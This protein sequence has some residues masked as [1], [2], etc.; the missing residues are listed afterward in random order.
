M[1]SVIVIG[2]GSAKRAEPAPARE[3]YI[4]SLFV[5]CRRYAEASGRPWAILSAAHGLVMPDSELDP[6]DARLVLRGP[7]LENW[8][9][10]AARG[11]RLRLGAREV[12]CLAG[13]T[14]AEPFARMLETLGIGC[15]MPLAGKGV[16]QR[17]AWLK[18]RRA[19]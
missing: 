12:E 9:M 4:G 10:S 16:G 7:A 8:A 14:Y 11:A 15:S 13:A 19:A 18:Q 6:Y 17:L 1:A 2:C 5:A 3:L